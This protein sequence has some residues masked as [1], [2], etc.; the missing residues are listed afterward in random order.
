MHQ[1]RLPLELISEILDFLARPELLALR[2][3]NKAFHALATPLAFQ[4]LILKDTVASAQGL[5]GLQSVPDAVECVTSVVFTS[6]SGKAPHFPPIV[7]VIFWPKPTDPDESSWEVS[8][9]A[10]P[11]GGQSDSGSESGLEDP[12]ADPRLIS[13]PPATAGLCK[14]PRLASLTFHFSDEYCEGSPW[15]MHEEEPSYHLRMQRAVL[16]AVSSHPLPALKS[17]TFKN[18]NATPSDVFVLPQFKALLRPL[19]TVLIDVLGPEDPLEGLY[20][21][22]PLVEFWGEQMKPILSAAKSVTTLRLSSNCLV[23]AMP[24]LTFPTAP[25]PQLTSL[26]LEKICF[27]PEAHAGGSAEQ[28]ILQHPA[29]RSLTLEECPLFCVEKAYARPWAT[30]FASFDKGLK[31]LVTLEIKFHELRYCY[32]DAGWGIISLDSD[33]VSVDGV[34][35]ERALEQ[36]KSN[37]EARRRAKLA[38]VTD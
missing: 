29:L 22:E 6:I 38:R 37:V 33:E 15:D 10:E 28:F 31:Q 35:D 2:Q 32:E 13:V 21:L 24:S 34:A 12:E 16:E 18:L 17:I 9:D 26:H 1:L 11:E 36:L 3:A 14:F 25:L 5:L 7:A 27:F 4:Q 20:A 19:E 8:T 23:G 30:V